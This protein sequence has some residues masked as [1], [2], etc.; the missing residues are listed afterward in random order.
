GVVCGLDVIPTEDNKGV[1]V[2][3]GLAIDC[4]GREILVCGDAKDRYVSLFPEDHECDQ[5]QIKEELQNDDKHIAICLEYDECK[6]EVVNLPSIVCDETEKHE[7][8][9]IRD[10]W[11]ITPIRIPQELEHEHFCQRTKEE[12]EQSLHRYLCEKTKNCQQCP[13]CSCIILAIVTVVNGEVEEIDTCNQRK[14][15]YSNQLLFDQINCYHGDLPRVTGIEWSDKPISDQTIEQISEQTEQ[16]I[17]KPVSSIAIHN[18]TIQWDDFVQKNG[19]KVTFNK[20]MYHETINKHTFLIAVIT[21]EHSTRYRLLKYIPSEEIYLIDNVDETTSA[22]FKFEKTW[23]EDEL[24][25]EKRSA[26]TQSD[27]G[28][29]FEIILRG[30]SIFSNEENKKGKALDGSFSGEFPSGNGTQGTDFLSW[31]HVES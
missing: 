21:I 13:E 10:S 6:R 17:E 27:E 23:I 7:F 12:K 9:R 25:D 24:E 4:C 31:F 29:D 11:K 18:Q 15:V 5:Q 26:I 2:T 19:L 20:R 14:L 22:I 28:A 16:T 8:N 30:S 3:P 1:E